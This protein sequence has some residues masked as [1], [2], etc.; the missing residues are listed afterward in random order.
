MGSVWGLYEG[1][2]GVGC[3]VATGVVKDGRVGIERKG[4]ERKGRDVKGKE[5][6][7]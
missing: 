4:R 2:W 1:V 7:R 3:R 5:F 6:R